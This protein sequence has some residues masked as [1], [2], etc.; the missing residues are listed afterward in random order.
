MHKYLRSKPLEGLAVR[1]V[2]HPTLRT[3][4][5]S[6]VVP[7]WIFVFELKTPRVHR[8][9]V[10]IIS[11]TAVCVEN[12]SFVLSHSYIVH[13]LTSIWSW[14]APQCEARYVPSSRLFSSEDNVSLSCPRE[15]SLVHKATVSTI[16]GMPRSLRISNIC[17]T[18]NRDRYRQL[19]SGILSVHFL[20]FFCVAMPQRITPIIAYQVLM[21]DVTIDL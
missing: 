15:E 4:S 18:G 8:L 9:I 21:Y 20:W 6:F 12:H 1:I 5:H 17:L 14:S 10:T 3:E 7:Y 2:S 19:L 11:H 13:V 16:S